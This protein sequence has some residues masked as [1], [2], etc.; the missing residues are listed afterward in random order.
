MCQ[1]E[2]AHACNEQA[3]NVDPSLVSYSVRKQSGQRDALFVVGIHRRH[4]RQRSAPHLR[5]RRLLTASGRKATV[6]GLRIHTQRHTTAHNLTITGPH[7]YYVLAGFV[8]VLVHN[9]CSVFGRKLDN[10]A[11]HLTERDL[12]AARRELNGEVVAR[13]PDGTPW[14]HLHEVRAAQNGLLNVIEQARRR[15]S[16]PRLDAESRGLLGADLSRASRMLDYSEK[17]VPR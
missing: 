5:N 10:I 11:T 3:I 6:A 2:L 14:N 7:T 12:S 13:K 9:S 4:Q 15:L 17:Y 1:L 16:D 8:P